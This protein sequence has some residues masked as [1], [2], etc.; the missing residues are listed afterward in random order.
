MR[1]DDLTLWLVES[2]KGRQHS[3]VVK[4]YVRSNLTSRRLKWASQCQIKQVHVRQPKQP[5]QFGT[6]T[7]KMPYGIRHDAK[8]GLYKAQSISRVSTHIHIS[9]NLKFVT[10]FWPIKHDGICS[11]RLDA[12]ASAP[13]HTAA[14]KLKQTNHMWSWSLGIV[15]SCQSIADSPSFSRI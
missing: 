9:H 5:E 7:K 14:V 3:T 1:K 8:G 12:G 6:E 13:L 11:L 15:Q 4:L 2:I 10:K